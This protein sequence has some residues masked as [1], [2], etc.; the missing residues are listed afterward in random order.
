MSDNLQLVTR[1]NT[2][3]SAAASLPALYADAILAADGNMKVAAERLTRVTREQDPNDDPN[4]PENRIKVTVAEMVDILATNPVQLARVG[5]TLRAS[6][7]LRVFDLQRD[8]HRILAANI[9]DLESS[10]LVKLYTALSHEAISATNN[11]TKIEITSD[12]DDNHMSEVLKALPDDVRR[13]V[14]QRVSSR[15]QMIDSIDERSS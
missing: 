1:T 9:A 2:N 14:I 13:A 8:V 11:T 15:Q 5:R 10:D 3:H 4:D 6:A 12:N 7:V